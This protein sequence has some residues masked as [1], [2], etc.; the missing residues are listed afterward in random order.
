MAG[1]APINLSVTVGDNIGLDPDDAYLCGA[2][3]KDKQ[4]SVPPSK[5]FSSAMS[6][7]LVGYFSR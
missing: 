2:I 3:D 5:E 7:L 1:V 6:G 4:F